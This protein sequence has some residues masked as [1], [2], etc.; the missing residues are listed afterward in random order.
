MK[1][2]VN[3]LFGLMVLLTLATIFVVNVSAADTDSSFI[4]YDDE[5]SSWTLHTDKVQQV[6]KFMNGSLLQLSLTDP[7][8]QYN[9]IQLPS[10]QPE[11]SVKV[12]GTEYK[13]DCG[14]SVSYAPL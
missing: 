7:T 2:V 14:T 8:T 13:S 11:F 6:I 10:T 3:K 5:N 1:R 9:Y 4:T 12:N